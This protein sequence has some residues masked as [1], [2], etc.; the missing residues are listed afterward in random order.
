MRGDKSETTG[1]KK[2]QNSKRTR[3]KREKT[4]RGPRNPNHKEKQKETMG[5]AMGDE[6]RK[7]LAKGTHMKETKG[8]RNLAKRT[9]TKRN[10]EPR[11]LTKGDHMKGDKGRQGAQEPGKGTHM[12]GDERRQAETSS[13]GTPQKEPT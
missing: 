6:E 1:D 8:P 2:P 7:S 5:E 11:N 12:K 4:G 13:S 10:K 9:Q 3:V